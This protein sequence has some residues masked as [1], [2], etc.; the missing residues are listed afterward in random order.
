MRRRRKS[1]TSSSPRAS[2]ATRMRSRSARSRSSASRPAPGVAGRVCSATSSLFGGLHADLQ[3]GAPCRTRPGLLGFN[4]PIILAPVLHRPPRADRQRLRPQRDARRGSTTCSRSASLDHLPVGRSGADPISRQIPIPDR[5][6]AVPP[7]R[8]PNPWLP[9]RRRRTARRRRSCRT[10]RPA[11]HRPDRAPRPSSTTTAST[12]RPTAPWPETTGCDQLSFNP[13]LYGAADDHADGHGIR[14]STSTSRCP[15]SRAR[16]SPRRHEIRAADGHPARGLLDQPERAPTARRP[17]PTPKRPSGPQLPAQLPRVL[18]GRHPRR[19]TARRCPAPIPGAI[20]LGEPLPGNRTGSSSPPTA[21]PPTSSSPGTVSADPVDRAAGRHLPGPAAEPA[22]AIQHALLR[23]RA[24]P[25]RDADPVRHL[26]GRNRRSSPGTSVLPDQNSTQFFTLDSGP[27]GGALPGP[28]ARLR[29]DASRPAARTTP[30][31]PTPVLAELDRDDGEQNLTAARRHD[32]AGL[33]R[34]PCRGPLLPGGGARGAGRSRYP[35]SPEQDS[36]PPLPGRQ[37]G[38]HRRRRRG[39]RATTPS[40]SPGKVYLAGPYKGAPLSL[41]VVTPAVSGPYDLGNVV[42]R[43]RRS[44]S[45]PSTAQVTRDLRPA[46]ADHRRDPAAAALGPDQPRPPEL[47]PQPDQLRPV[48]GRRHGLR[49][50]RR[51]RQP[52]ASRFQVANCAA[53][54]FAPEAQPQAAAAA[55]SAAVIRRCTRS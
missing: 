54:P 12:A 32:A 44:T 13:S 40:T 50:P 10:R 37:P 14:A 7:G 23:L 1:S 8:Y 25:A 38:R 5:R 43:V 26:P 41:A 52:R 45:T 31:A 42:V 15:S 33:P 18:Q 16:P 55:P 46:P 36:S 24:R 22:P 17:A 11:R 27:N 35:A 6:A 49:R 2:S 3:H 34:R 53:L 19:S 39:R 9:A 28:P 51:D 21:S 20:Y 30:P 29:P 48:L 4:I 47:H